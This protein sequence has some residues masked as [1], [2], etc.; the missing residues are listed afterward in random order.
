MRKQ[1]PL[2]LLLLAPAILVSAQYKSENLFYMVDNPESFE[3]F[4]KNAAQISIVSPQVFNMSKEGV[5]TGS[6]HP[7]ILEVAKANNVKV[8]P[9]IVNTGF[10]TAILHAVVSSPIARKRAIDMMLVFA[11]QY[12]LDGWQ[13]DMEGLNIEDREN[14]TTFFRQTADSLH[15]HNLQLSAAVVHATANTGGTDAYHKFL[16]EDWRAGYD[17]RAMALAGDFIS[18][19][20]YGQHTRRTTP[21]PVAGADWVDRVIQYLLKEGVPPQKLSLGIPSYSIHW[22]TDYTDE[23]GGFSTS[24]SLNYTQLHYLMERYDAKPQ[25]NEKAKVNYLIVDNDGV[26]EYVFIEDG[27]SLKPKLDILKKYHLRGISV[28]VLGSEGPDF[29]TTLSQSIIRN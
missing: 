18:I 10:N 16:Y 27:A 29:W 3:S 20:T 8:M 1:L 4:R 11:Q 7:K 23:K 13:F 12:H 21:G 17:F 22:Y 24:H 26:F 19:M 2:L 5:L 6:I 14:F 9:L 28:W 25:W 15:H